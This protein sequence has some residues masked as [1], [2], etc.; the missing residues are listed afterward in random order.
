MSRFCVIVALL[1]CE[2]AYA[3]A[4]EYQFERS[5]LFSISGQELFQNSDSLFKPPFGAN[6]GSGELSFAA[7]PEF[8]VAYGDMMSSVSLR[9]SQGGG[10]PVTAT[11]REAFINVDAGIFRFSGGR[12]LL[13]WGTAYFFNPI[14]SFIPTRSATD[15]SDAGKSNVG[16][17]CIR[18]D[19]FTEHFMAGALSY[20]Q[21]D[22]YGYAGLF[23]AGTDFIDTYW[24]IHDGGN[25]ELEYGAAA[26]ATVA[27]FLEVHAEIV[28]RRSV[29]VLAHRVDSAED[30]HIS[31]GTDGLI[32]KDYDAP[33]MWVAGLNATIA[34][35]NVIAEWYHSDAGIGKKE[36]D[37]EKEYFSYNNDR[38]MDDFDVLDDCSGIWT[39]LRQQY[40][41]RDYGFIRAAGSLENYD[42]SGIVIMNMEDHS[43]LCIGTVGIALNNSMSLTVNAMAMGGEK[44]SEYRESLIGS[45][46]SMDLRITF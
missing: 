26:A 45:I 28:R 14:G 2:I 43:V 21:N 42:L 30:P 35:V 38:I 39:L 7:I 22:T 10:N 33:I 16:T 29:D 23:Y 3:R 41:F 4:A 15:L 20:Y 17:D 11:V 24:M 25:G 46:L 31:Y 12:K 6:A 32:M 37:R 1:L 8:R 27:D 40:R 44:G 34:Q 13:Q 18:A 5:V 9:F 19:I 36:W